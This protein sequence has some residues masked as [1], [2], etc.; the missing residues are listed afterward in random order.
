[1]TKDG[2]NEISQS[3]KALSCQ[4][5]EEKIQRFEDLNRLAFFKSYLD[6]IKSSALA[7]G[8]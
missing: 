5:M 8:V 3:P 2:N 7:S 6:H 4:S 1:M